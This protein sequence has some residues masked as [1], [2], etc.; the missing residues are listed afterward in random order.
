M[1]NNYINVISSDYFQT[2]EF[3]ALYYDW[4]LLIPSLDNLIQYDI[5]D[6]HGTYVK[7]FWINDG[8]NSGWARARLLIQEVSDG[9]RVS[10]RGLICNISATQMIQNELVSMGIVANE[11]LLIASCLNELSEH[12]LGYDPTE[13]T[14]EFLVNAAGNSEFDRSLIDLVY[15]WMEATYG[16]LE[17]P[18]KANQVVYPD[19]TS[20]LESWDTKNMAEVMGSY[21]GVDLHNL[22]ENAAEDYPDIFECPIVRV[23][24]RDPIAPG[25]DIIVI[26]GYQIRAN[27]IITTTEEGGVNQHY[28][29]R[30]THYKAA[31]YH[32]YEGAEFIFDGIAE[33]DTDTGITMY[34]YPHWG[35]LRYNG[36]TGGNV[37]GTEYFSLGYFGQA[38]PYTLLMPP[39]RP[40]W[41]TGD[42]MPLSVLDY[43]IIDPENPPTPPSR[44]IGTIPPN[45][46]IGIV[47]Y[48]G[49]P[50]PKKKD[51]PAPETEPDISAVEG[52]YGL[53]KVFKISVN[54]VGELGAFLWQDDNLQAVLNIFK[55]NPM[56][57]VISLQQMYFDPTALNTSNIKLGL[58]DTHIVAPFINDRYQE[59]NC[60]GIPIK[61]YFGDIR[62][63]QT[64][65]TLYLPFI[66]FKQLRAEDIVSATTDTTY[67][68]V[69]YQIDC[70]TGDC[71]ATLTLNRDGLQDK[72]TLYTFTGNCANTLPLTGAD[73]SRIYSNIA[74][75]GLSALT[76]NVAGA[77]ASTVGALT[78]HNVSIEKSG[79]MSGNCGAMGQKKP[80]IIISRPQPYDAVKRELFEGLPSNVATNLRQLSGFVK[81][82]EIHVESIPYATDTEKELISTLLK[83][84]VIL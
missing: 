81:V 69:R 46:T 60:Q 45:I 72:K 63:F 58:V 59:L 34:N 64:D 31:S 14:V 56:D 44:Q 78:S 1:A 68:Y 65:Y 48:I 9:Y 21:Y 29:A 35:A 47:P 24:R 26:A 62:D 52:L 8:D 4:Y 27:E 54:Q 32:R 41:G 13:V 23:F 75:I 76:G 61:R 20:T 16:P 37:F 49:Y 71:V 3:R 83:Q 25:Y 70:Y 82:K 15:N 42:T 36:I 66:G 11:G 12:Y 73:K 19:G 77:A 38:K 67:L 17:N 18:Y 43:P 5:Y 28:E 79:N 10:V 50:K 55:N 6:Y 40:A 2:E 22:V 51:E 74:N 84:G 33:D 30:V 53:F 39:T 80:Y 57:A 7:D